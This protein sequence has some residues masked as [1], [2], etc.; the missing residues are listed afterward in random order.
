MP[1]PLLSRRHTIDRTGR[2]RVRVM[3]GYEVAPQAL[4]A[5]SA[6]GADH[7]Q[8]MTERAH[9]VT[10]LRLADGTFGRSRAAADLLAAYE[11]CL[12]SHAD[13]LMTTAGVMRDSA[14]ATATAADQ[15]LAADDVTASRTTGLR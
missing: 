13:T 5:F 11:R 3:G 6:T 12:T 7:G 15:Y 4:A 2:R 9:A 8:D 10:A 1:Y 14:D